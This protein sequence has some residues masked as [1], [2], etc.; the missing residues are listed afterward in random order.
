MTE[1]ARP[2]KT[3]ISLAEGHIRSRTKNVVK[4]TPRGPV[5]TGE[6]N[7]YQKLAKDAGVTL[8]DPNA[9]PQ[10]LA[11]EAYDLLIEKQD[12]KIAAQKNKKN[13]AAESANPSLSAGDLQRFVAEGSVDK[14]LDLYT[15]V[16]QHEM[17]D[18]L[19]SQ[20]SDEIDTRLDA[21]LSDKE[22]FDT[23]QHGYEKGMQIAQSVSELKKLDRLQRS[24]TISEDKLALQAKTQKRNLTSVERDLIASNQVLQ[25]SIDTRKATLLE[26]PEISNGYRIAKLKEIQRQLRTDRFAEMP[27]RVRKMD[28]IRKLIANGNKVLMTGP[29]GTGKTELWF[30]T[31]RSL[32]GTKGEYVTGRPDMTMYEVYG[33]TGIGIAADGQRG[34]VFKGGKLT[35]SFEARGGR[36]CPFLWD[37]IDNSKN[38]IVMGV[39]THLN[40]Q[41]GDTL[42][43]QMDGDQTYTAG[44][45]WAFGATANVKSEKYKTRVDL[46]PAIIRVFSPVKLEFMPKEELYDVLI[47]SQIDS[48]GGLSIQRGDV[49]G[50]L[51]N[52]TDAVEW[53]QQA[54]EGKTVQTGSG[55]NDIL[56]ARGGATTGKAASLEKAVIDPGIAQKMLEGYAV[57]KA[58]G[59]P[60]VTY[61]NNQL[62]GFINNENFSDDDRY[63]LTRILTLKNFLGDK[64]ASDFNI[65]GLDE[66]TFTDWTRNISQPEKV[67]PKAYMRAE[68][69]AQLDP[70]NV[71]HLDL[72][73]ASDDLLGTPQSKSEKKGKTS[74]IFQK[75]KQM[76]SVIGNIAAPDTSRDIHALYIDQLKGLAETTSNADE[77]LEIA[78][79]LGDYGQR[80]A[81][82]SDAGSV[83]SQNYIAITRTAS[84]YSTEIL[85]NVIENNNSFETLSK[86]VGNIE[87]PDRNRKVHYAY[88]NQLSGLGLESNSRSVIEYCL[89][90]C[91]EYAKKGA[92]KS[93]SGSISDPS[94]WSQTQHAKE[95][96]DKLRAKLMSS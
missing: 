11:R 24:I 77:L 38:E 72:K 39:K 15:H 84:T 31:A 19:V 87:K 55:P 25:Q 70:Y 81:Y 86:A 9:P 57:E 82:K 13:Q 92:Y 78:N 93:E 63:Y 42:T 29:S 51:V 94:Y 6:F 91:D 21:L 1:P 68:E 61:L 67:N 80:G 79:A 75:I 54:Y 4:P 41:P 2:L 10:D 90:L 53:I 64:Q 23:Y 32:F 46:D 66:K 95:I 3:A 49:E 34:D 7:A 89:N 58:K 45:D 88:L 65:K 96:A 62:T 37:E 17:A 85:I 26:N 8:N 83:L 36:G 47:A 22:V 56:A 50:T 69:V 71:I 60:L 76:Q 33:R 52:F 30:H 20:R 18:S 73:T 14:V 12:L 5:L 27:S 59:V 74:A 35:K 16:D 28:Q 48:R 44:P 40:V 43:I